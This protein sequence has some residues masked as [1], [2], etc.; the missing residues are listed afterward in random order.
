MIYFCYNMEVR[1][2][3]PHAVEDLGRTFDSPTAELTGS[4]T[5]SV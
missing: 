4:L 3:D 5:E 1:D 2:A